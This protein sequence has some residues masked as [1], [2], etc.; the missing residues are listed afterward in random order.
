MVRS[1]EDSYL[2]Y[3]VSCRGHVVAG[4]EA[5][6]R[7]FLVSTLLPKELLHPKIQKRSWP[8]FIRS[9]FSGAVFKACHELEVAVRE[10]ADLPSRL[11][12][13]PLVDEAFKPHVGPLAD[14]Q[15]LEAEQLALRRLFSGAIGSYKNP[16]S[17]RHVELEP[18]EAS[19]MLVLASYLLSIVDAR[20]S[21]SVVHKANDEDE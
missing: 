5:A 17:H 14:T 7:E 10:A 13:V 12:G 21:G 11:V 20:R 8:D 6:Q 9:D 16:N 15:A 19:E 4:S 1:L 2:K 3:R 18:Q